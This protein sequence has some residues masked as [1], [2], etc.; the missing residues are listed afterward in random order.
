MSRCLQE[1]DPRYLDQIEECLRHPAIVYKLV[2][3]EYETT[4]VLFQAVWPSPDTVTLPVG[5]SHMM[6]STGAYATATITA[7]NGVDRFV[8]V[9]DPTTPRLHST[10][11]RLRVRSS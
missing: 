1:W 5:I 2:G 7:Q 6:T 9:A 10:A 8:H 3:R 4:S 11:P